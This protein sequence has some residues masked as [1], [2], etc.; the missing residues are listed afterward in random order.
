MRI[1]RIALNNPKGSLV[2]I[3]MVIFFIVSISLQLFQNAYTTQYIP[4][5]TYTYEKAINLF[6]DHLKPDHARPIGFSILAGIPKLFVSKPT[7]NQLITWNYFINIVMWVLTVLTIYKAVKLNLNKKSSILLSVLFILCVANIAQTSVLLTETV[8]CFLITLI[9]YN[10]LLFYKKKSLVNFI[11]TIVLVNISVLIKPG[12]IYLAA[13]F[14]LIFLWYY[15]KKNYALSFK[16]LA[17]LAFT[18]FLVFSQSLLMYHSHGKF[19]VSFIDKYTWYLYL[20]AE[21]NA[22]ANTIDYI[23]ERNDRRIRIE[24]LSFENRFTLASDDF[25]TQLKTHPEIIIKNLVSNICDNVNVGNIRISSATDFND[26]QN[27]NYVRYYLYLISKAQNIVFSIF[28]LLVTLLALIRIKFLSL[29]LFLSCSIICYIIIT[30][31]ISFWEGDRFN[32]VFYPLV[33]ISCSYL[34]KEIKWFKPA[35]PITE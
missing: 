2:F 19:T 16:L 6:Y 29:A 4:S 25:R 18:W 11:I 34:L 30:S 22:E 1:I 31:G 28:G 24:P 35:K 23:T 7:I 13:F 27:F 14:N 17:P 12:M 26:T 8:S 3:A 21:S 9:G 20:G 5:D 33:L 32:I 10:L 15:F